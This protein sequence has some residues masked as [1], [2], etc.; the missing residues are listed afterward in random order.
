MLY[1]KAST[2]K[3]FSKKLKGWGNYLLFKI[4]QNI[5]WGLEVQIRIDHN[6]KIS[7]HTNKKIKIEWQRKEIW[8]GLEKYSSKYQMHLVQASLEAL[9][10]N[11]SHKVTH[12]LISNYTQLDVISY[13]KPPLGCFI[14]YRNMYNV[15]LKNIKT[16]WVQSFQK[17]NLMYKN[18]YHK[19]EV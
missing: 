5:D 11:F 6:T 14:R 8:N 19:I 13:L 7:F 12:F 15:L 10:M 9:K 1:A 3:P 2:Y 18:K 16:N 17:G 4:S